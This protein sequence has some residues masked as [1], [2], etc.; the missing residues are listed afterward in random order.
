MNI[1]VDARLL[2]KDKLEGAGYFTREV[3]RILA[4]QHPQHRFYFL[5]DQPYD[6]ELIFSENIHPLMLPPSARHPVLRKYWFDM[7]LPVM[8]RKIG[9]D[10]FVA[11]NGF[12]SLTTKIP[13]CLVVHDPGFFHHPEAHRKSHYR[14]Y[15][16]YAPS[17]LKKSQPHRY[18]F[19]VF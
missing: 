9:A 18:R 12:C 13:Q 14:F 8:L 10:V 4:R 15:R 7:K 11:A 5:F 2:L 1:A 17:F 19:G 3:F 16:H 6:G